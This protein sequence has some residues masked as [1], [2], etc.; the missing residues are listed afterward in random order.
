MNHEQK[1]NALFIV[2]RLTFI[3]MTKRA[4]LPLP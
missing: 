4:S 1:D 3:V 2:Y